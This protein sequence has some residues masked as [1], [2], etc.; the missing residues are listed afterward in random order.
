MKRRFTLPV[1][2]ADYSVTLRRQHPKV[3]NE[4][5]LGF[6]YYAKRQIEVYDNPVNKELTR[7]TLWHEW[8]HAVLR[9]L[10][11]SELMNDEALVDGIANALMRVRLKEPWL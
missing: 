4:K 11:R 6:C 2:Y 1:L 10:G 5:V 3:E 8:T 9:E 7:A